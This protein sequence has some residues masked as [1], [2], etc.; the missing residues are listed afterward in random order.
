M[1][2]VYMGT[3][4]FAVEPLN[5]LIE[6]G[7]HEIALVVTQP[8]KPKGRGKQMQVTPVK[9]RALAAG[10]PVAQPEKVRG[11]EAFLAELTDIAPDLIV[12]AAF[13]QILPEAVLNCPKY[14]C[15]NVHA[16]LLPK[17]R[18][19]APIQWAV[20]NGD[21]KTGITIMQM[22]KGLDTGDILT[23]QEIYLDADE[24]GG[25]LFDKLALASKQQLL[26]TI[27]QIEAGTLVPQVQ[28]DAESSYAKMLSKTTGEIDSSKSAV[29]L[30]RLVRG[31]NPWP[32]TFTHIDGKMLKIWKVAIVTPD[33]I[34]ADRLEA[35]M[36]Y[37]EGGRLFL[38]CGNASALELLE[39]QLEGKKRMDTA[40]FLRGYTIE[41]G[42]RI[43]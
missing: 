23:Q 19:A 3:P 29:E 9:E 35:G 4:D 6:S 37:P 13:G 40:S 22:A 8:D 25:S 42:T 27:D 10:I 39:V 20:I 30:E 21:E 7:K 15:I 18:G 1:K 16:S 11:N 32:G 31:C 5:A 17:Y 34:H 38:A 33:L 24:T 28:N 14:G 36:L 2:I 43:G 41:S 12:V 26:D